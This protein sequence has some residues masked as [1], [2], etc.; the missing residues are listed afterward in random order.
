MDLKLTGKVA[1]V[2]GSGLATAKAFAAERRRPN[3]GE[4][5]TAS[6]TKPKCLPM[7]VDNTE[8]GEDHPAYQ[9]RG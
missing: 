7:I 5:K 4:R 9:Y 3:L 6:F 2:T 8:I 1:L